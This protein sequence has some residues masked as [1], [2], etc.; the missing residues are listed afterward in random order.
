[1]KLLFFEWHSFMNKGIE[2][3]LKELEIPYDTFFYQFNDWERM[4]LFRAVSSLFK[5]GN[6]Y[7]RAV[8]QFFAIDFDVV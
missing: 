7:G 1:M 5:G 8:G 3:G 6:L 4:M 2:R